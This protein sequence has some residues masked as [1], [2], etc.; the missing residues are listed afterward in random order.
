VSSL[1][2]DQTVVKRL[3]RAEG[4]AR[5]VA[6]GLNVRQVR[7]ELDPA[8]LRAAALTPADV[9][10]AL[11]RSNADEPVG[12]V[13]NGTTDAIVRVEGRVRDP[14]DFAQIVV[15]RTGNSVTTLGDLG[16]VVETDQEAESMSRVNGDPAITLQVYKQKDANIVRAGESI[17]D[18]VE[19]M[20][21]A[22]RRASSCA[23]STPTATGCRTR[24]TGCSAP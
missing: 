14:K 16:Q 8:R 22:C 11:K 20:Q 21:A 7:V 1:L 6:S 3:E 24:C 15:A 19:S 18:A 17:K 12:L 23:S 10:E 5:V 2:A 9:A 13:S 4:V